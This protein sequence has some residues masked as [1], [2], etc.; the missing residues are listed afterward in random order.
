MLTATNPKT[1]ETRNL[2]CDGFGSD[3]Y[4]RRVRREAFDLYRDGWRIDGP[5]YH[6]QTARRV[7]GSGRGKRGQ[8]VGPFYVRMA[9]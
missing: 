7:I 6:G 9:G 3:R 5:E 8:F 4:A 1:G 2:H